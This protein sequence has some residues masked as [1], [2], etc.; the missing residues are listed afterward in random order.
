MSYKS[1]IEL[2][3]EQYITYRHYFRDYQG[4][5]YTMHSMTRGIFS[6]CV[7]VLRLF[8][9]IRYTE[10]RLQTDICIIREKISKKNVYSTE[11]CRNELQLADCLTKGTVNCMKLLE[12]IGSGSHFLE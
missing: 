4:L 7:N 2:Q 12:K 9:V 10:K 8:H 6:I 5:F 1:Y 11:S 3:N